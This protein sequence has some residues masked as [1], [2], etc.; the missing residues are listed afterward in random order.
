LAK[1]EEEERRATGLSAS[2]SAGLSAPQEAQQVQKVR[3]VHEQEHKETEELEILEAP[4]TEATLRA[5]ARSA[6]GTPP[7]QLVDHFAANKDDLF[8]LLP[9]EP[10][11]G[12]ALKIWVNRK[13]SRSA[14]ATSGGALTLHVGFN[15]W[16]LG[17]A[18][19]QFLEQFWAGEVDL[20]GVEVRVPM[21]A[22]KMSFVLSDGKGTF[23]NN[24]GHDFDLAC[25]QVRKF[26]TFP[27][28]SLNVP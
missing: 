11:P 26:P 13:A 22:G 27:E 16:K 28:C 18:T 4:V 8:L 3:K 6:A 9:R 14:L 1:V 24:G 23:D 12:E 19:I 7:Q 10:V 20:R 25:A 21:E 15:D 17:T 2:T 5:D